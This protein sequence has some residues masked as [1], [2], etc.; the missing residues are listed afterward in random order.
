MSQNKI[1]SSAALYQE[2]ETLYFKEHFHAILKFES[3]FR[4]IDSCGL[5]AE[6]IK[7]LYEI[8]AR[9]Y[10][11]LDKLDKAIQVIDQRICFLSDKDISNAEHAEDLLIFTLLKIEVF[12]KEGSFKEEYKS[13]LAYEKIGGSDN[14]IL[15][16]RI[17]V[18]EALFMQYVKVNKYIFYIILLAVLLVNLD[19]I[20]SNSAYLPTLTVIAVIWY[21]MNYVMNCRVKRLYLKILRFIYS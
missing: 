10:L 14:Q 5:D 1:N 17:A 6:K 20:P 21:L 13:I 8:F 2:I 3:V 16:M 7:C 18:E 19:F 4:E 9:T 15:N 11:E 12:Q